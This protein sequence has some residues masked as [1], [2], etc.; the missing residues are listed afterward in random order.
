MR[1]KVCECSPGGRW[2][3]SLPLLNVCDIQLWTANEVYLVVFIR[4]QHLGGIN[5]VISI[6]CQFKYLF[7]SLARKCLF[8]SHWGFGRCDPINGSSF[9]VTTKRHHLVQST[10]YDILIVKIGR[11]ICMCCYTHTVD[12]Y[13]RYHTNLC[14]S[15]MTMATESRNL[16]ML[17]ILP[18]GFY[19]C[20]YY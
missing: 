17:N 1:T 14:G 2:W 7:S 8:C 13:S 15:C 5:A 4:K 16:A 20:L 10:S 6:M 11:W 19:N 3:L 12:I 18:V 9:I